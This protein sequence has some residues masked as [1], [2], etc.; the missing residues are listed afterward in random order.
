MAP[1]RSTPLHW[2]AS[3]PGACGQH[4]LDSVGFEKKEDMKLAGSERSWRGSEEGY[5]QCILYTHE[6]FKE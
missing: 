5:D 4:K 2:M 1:E 6:I 3:H